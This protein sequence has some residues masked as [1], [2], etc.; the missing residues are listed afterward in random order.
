MHPLFTSSFRKNILSII[1]IIAIP[2]TIIL[3]YVEIGLNNL[4]T[5]YLKKRV[6]FE[7]QLNS[8]EV[9]SLGSSNAYYGINPNEFSCAGYNLAINAQSMYYDFEFIKKYT[10]L[11][12]NLKVVIL[13]AIFYTTGTKL[14]GTSQ[15]WRMYFYKQYFELPNETEDGNTTNNVKR[16]IDSR[17]FSKIALY[18]DTLY[19]HVKNGFSGHVDYIPESNGWYD[20]KD[21]PR[22]NSE[23]NVATGAAVAHS[24]SYDVKIAS[25]NLS[26][27]QEIIDISKKQKIQVILVRLPEDISITSKLDKNK[28][29]HFTG[30]MTELALKNNIQFIDYSKDQRFYS[31][32]YTFMPDHLNPDGAIKFSKVLNE[33]YIFNACKNQ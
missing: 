24:A 3:V 1:F 14:V 19:A 23:N 13:P 11:M 25:K 2:A 7:K 26:Y 4:D 15:D 28:I 5:H 6:D 29:E 31:S 8:I 17:N 9:L 22:L 21:V 33:D 32:D 30:L 18:S 16:F 20:S 12:P 27:W 10:P